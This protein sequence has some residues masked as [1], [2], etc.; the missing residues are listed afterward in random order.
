MKRISLVSLAVAVLFGCQ[1][2]QPLTP[3]FQGPSAL[4]QDAGHN[5]G[6]HFFAFLQPMVSQPSTNGVFDPNLSPVVMVDLQSGA[7]AAVTITYTM[8]TGPGSERVRVNAADRNYIVNLHTDQ[9]PVSNGCTYRIHVLV[10]STELG[11]ADVELFLTQKEAKNLAT[12]ETVALVDGKTLPIK[13]WIAGGALCASGADCGQ[14]TAYPDRDNVIVTQN[15][16]AGVFIPAGAVDAVVTIIIESVDNRPCIPGLVGQTFEGPPGAAANSCYE[17]RADPPLPDGTFNTNVIVGICVE[18]S[19]VTETQEPKIQ[20]FQ[21]DDGELPRIRPLPN[22]AAPFLPCDPSYQAPIGLAKPGLLNLAARSFGQLLSSLAALAEPRPLFASTRTMVF[23]LGAGGS[24]DGF[25]F[26]TWGLVTSMAKND[27]DGQSAVVGTPVA[28]PPSV[29]FTDS[30]GAPVDSV[31]VTFTVGS[32]G[33][34]VTGASTKSGR[35]GIAGVARVGSWTLGVTPGSNTL[36]ASAPSGSGVINSPLLFT[37]TGTGAADLIIESLT[38]SPASPT[39]AD[40]MEFGVTVKN[41]GTAATGSFY[42]IVNTTKDGAPLETTTLPPVSSLAA[43]ESRTLCCW[44]SVRAAGDYSQTAIADFH[45]D[46]ELNNQVPES[47]EENNTLTDR[48]TVAAAPVIDGILSAGEWDRASQTPFTVN[49]PG[50]TAQGTLFVMNDNQNLYLAVR[51]ARDVVD[52]T[53]LLGFEFDNNNNASGPE[54]GDEY[55]NFTPATGFSDAFRST[56]GELPAGCVTND[57]TDGAGAFHNDGAFSVYELSH[58]LNSG[59]TG[60]D[61]AL[62]APTRIGMLLQLTVGTAQTRFPAGP[63]PTY[64]TISITAP[65][66]P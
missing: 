46:P 65:A 30:T 50:G 49:V 48:Y 31:P 61:F 55:F 62:I 34:S 22:A 33:G 7:C 42:V 27:G 23:D 32:G 52:E 38:H 26:F 14:G 51:F 36:S 29:S 25:S 9:V 41:Q 4:I 44:R 8:S 40:L 2:D 20:I 39:D 60:K 17:F 59:E 1:A 66:S 13:F 10:G 11:V 15:M 56:C 64:M 54:D 45:T 63:F 6:N 12:G 18:L 53:N 58:A 24:T 16:Q 37:A 57:R 3:P 43:N 35:G 28:I 21:F 19:G 5:N 47:N